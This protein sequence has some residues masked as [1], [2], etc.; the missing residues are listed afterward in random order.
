MMTL[1]Q[2]LEV[3]DV[4]LKHNIDAILAGDCARAN[5]GIIDWSDVNF[6]QLEVDADQE[7]KIYDLL[8]FM[9]SFYPDE[10]EPVSESVFRFM[11]NQTLV[12]V[13]VK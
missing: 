4:L 3:K 9:E 2:V 1:E 7:G 8:I 13:T 11:I 5:S 6:I 12:E 10:S